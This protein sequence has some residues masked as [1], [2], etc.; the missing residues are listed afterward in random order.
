MRSPNY[1]GRGVAQWRINTRSTH[2]RPL[3]VCLRSI[4]WRNY[5]SCCGW[6]RI[7]VSSACKQQQQNKSTMLSESYKL[8]STRAP[9]QLYMYRHYHRGEV[10][11]QQKQTH[12][13]WMQTHL[14]PLLVL[15]GQKP[16]VGRSES[17]HYGL[18][19]FL[20]NASRPS[21]KCF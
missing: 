20:P 7:G 21:R 10:A 13:K 5:A 4:V 17:D 19:T 15:L 1:I 3:F 16:T 2:R 18:L 9:G 14:Y 6:G 12:F 11:C 8:T